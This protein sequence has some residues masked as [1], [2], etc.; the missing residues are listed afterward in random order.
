[1]AKKLQIYKNKRDFTTTPEPKGVVAHSKGLPIFVVQEHHASHLHYDFR[2]EVDGVLKS[3]AVPKG[4]STDPADKR[5][6][7]LTEDHPL[8]YASFEGIIPEG[9][10]AGTV[11]VWDTGTYENATKIEG[12]PVTMAEAFAHGHIKIILRGTKLHG[13]YALTQFRDSNWLL[14]KI[15]DED[16]DA[17]RN[18]VNTE[19]KSVLSGT[20][21]EE[22]D[23]KMGRGSSK[24]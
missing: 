2:L 12:K 3:W 9:Y 24:K 1:M 10:G 5:L 18:P 6:A 16:A 20:T 13:G 14:V 22:L 17:R 7:T 19:P 11:I 8:A 23:K 21:I 4:P 15:R